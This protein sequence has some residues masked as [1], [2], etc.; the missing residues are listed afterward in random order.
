MVECVPF[1][2]PVGLGEGVH[3]IGKDAAGNNAHG[4]F[5]VHFNMQVCACCLGT[6]GIGRMLW[7][8]RRTIVS[9]LL[10]PQAL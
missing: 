7:V 4:C 2:H 5:S 1:V 10:L 3:S 9:Q 6:A 8:C